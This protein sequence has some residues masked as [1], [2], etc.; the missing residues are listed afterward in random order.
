MTDLLPF[1]PVWPVG[2]ALVVLGLACAAARGRFLAPLGLAAVA[3]EGARLEGSGLPAV[4]ALAILAVVGFGAL[5]SMR[6]GTHTEIRAR[7][8]PRPPSSNTWARRARKS[9]WSSMRPAT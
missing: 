7:R 3:L 5:G 4:G 2:S 8:P 6:A 1:L 9:S